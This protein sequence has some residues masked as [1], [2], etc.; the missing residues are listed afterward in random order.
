M[1]AEDHTRIQN[2]YKSP[3]RQDTLLERLQDQKD[4]NKEAMSFKMKT[5]T[6]RNNLNHEFDNYNRK[7][8]KLNLLLEIFSGR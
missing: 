6:N 1:K 2:P 5:N 7:A 8:K 4:Y 3:Y